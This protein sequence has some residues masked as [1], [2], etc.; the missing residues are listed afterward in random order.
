MFLKVRLPVEATLS[1]LLGI[2]I[3]FL[4]FLSG[5]GGYNVVVLKGLNI[6]LLIVPVL[7]IMLLLIVVKL[8]LQVFFGLV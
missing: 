4:H 1:G 2:G 6:Y 7:S 8:R 3:G 5:D